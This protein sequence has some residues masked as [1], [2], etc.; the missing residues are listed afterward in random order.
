MSALIDEILAVLHAHA[1][2]QSIRVVNY[3]ET[4]NGKLEL[5]IRCKLIQN[6]QFQ[7]WLHHEPAFRDYAYRLFTTQPILRWDNAPHYPHIST[8]PHH[9]HEVR[10]YTAVC[11]N[12][13]DDR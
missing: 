2:V 7:L 11:P 10:K 6:F 4:P 5:K 3:D 8:S 12:W 9:F 1:V 13:K